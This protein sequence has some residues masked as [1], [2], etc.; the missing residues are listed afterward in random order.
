MPSLRLFIAIVLVPSVAR[1][2]PITASVLD[3]E[4]NQPVAGA[5]VTIRS[6]T[7]VTDPAGH[8]LIGDLAG[9]VDVTVTA[10][11]YEVMTDTLSPDAPAVILLFRPGATGEAITI[12]D[13]APPPSARASTLITRDIIRGLPGG[14]EDA[15]AAVRSMP[16]VGQAPPTSGGRLVIRGSAPEDTRLTVDGISVPFLYHAFNNTTIIP[17]ANIAGI[18]YTPGGFGVEEGRATGGVVALTTDDTQPARPTATASV[19]LLEVA[20]Q[21]AAPISREHRLGISGSLRR[22]TVDFLAP[23]AV[24]DS[25]MVGFTTAPRFYD[26]QLRLDWRPSERD[27][28]AVLGLLSSDALGVINKDPDSELPSAFSSETRFARLIASWKRK[29]ERF[30]NRLVGA[31]GADRWDAEIG[32]DQN[33]NGHNRSFVLR[34]DLRIDA[35]KHVQVRA[36][37]SV[38]LADITVHALSILPPS[39]GLPPGRIDQL[40]IHM[41]DSRHDANYAAA[42]VA[43]D[44]LPTKAMTISPGVRV[45]AFGHLG[46]VRVLPRIQ[47]RHR[48]G[49]FTLTAALGRYARDLDQAEGV[50][51]DLLPEIATQATLGGE[52]VV[53]EGVTY[54]LAG[55]YTRRRDLVVEDPTRTAVD[56]LPFRTGGTGASTGFETL[57]RAQRGNFFAWFAYTFSRSTRRDAPD[58]PGRPF[59]YDQTHLVSVVGSYERGPWRYGARWQLATGLPY[60]E[61]TSATFSPELDHYVP[62][63]GPPDAARLDTS[64]QL[65]LRVERVIHRRTYQLAVFADLGNVYRRARVLR[66]QY[67]NDFMSR[68]P[69]S[70]MMPLPSIGVR[71]EF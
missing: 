43:T 46:Q 33:V 24:P 62:T 2:A 20:A 34:D 58:T 9:P 71:G 55:F 38:E 10:P 6:S 60:T 19:S 42:Y 8:V 26:G 57:L 67:S 37:G 11:G 25:V 47:A 3:V 52:L 18:E 15:L 44:L 50:P 53:A 54:S 28:V 12:T 36:G 7:F 32:I 41:I 63:F 45:D 49:P 5:T 69:V 64:H 40:P 65:D 59:A 16:G 30:D 68:K 17:V 4:T 31:L 48:T 51:R 39:E 22:S 56:E 13:H 29:E 23:I 61:I 1:A 66:Y 70:D 14:G 27:K 35:G 21:A